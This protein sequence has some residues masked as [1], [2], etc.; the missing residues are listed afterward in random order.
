[1]QNAVPA[2]NMLLSLATRGAGDGFRKPQLL[3]S[4]PERCLTRAAQFA[5]LAKDSAQGVLHLPIGNHLH[6]M[7]FRL[8]ETHGRF[9]KDMTPA[10]FLFIGGSGT[11]PQ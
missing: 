2:W 11:L 6:P 1:M 4:V 9:P 3:L 5:K 8:H 7:I 10:N